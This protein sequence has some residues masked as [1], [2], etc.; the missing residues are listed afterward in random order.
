MRAIVRDADENVLLVRHTYTPGW[1]SA[2]RRG[3]ARRDRRSAALGRELEEEAGVAITAPPRPA[4]GL[5]QPAPTRTATYDAGLYLVED[6]SPADDSK[7]RA[8]EIAQA[9]FSSTR[10]ALPE[11]Y[12]TAGHSSAELAELVDGGRFAATL[13]SR[14]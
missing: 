5:L 2:R 11:S 13:V 6:Y 10:R 9:R 8:R 12:T 14:A 3:R 7:R 1:A 4:R